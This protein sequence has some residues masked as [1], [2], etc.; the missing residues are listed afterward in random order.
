MTNFNIRTSCYALAAVASVGFGH[1]QP[2]QEGEG[3]AQRVDAKG[4]ND[5]Q[6]SF[7]WSAAEIDELLKASGIMLD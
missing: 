5:D 6:K 1:K 7:Q 4:C 2:G 3:F